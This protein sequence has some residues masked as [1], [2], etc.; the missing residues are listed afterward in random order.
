M[1]LYI[2]LFSSY[3]SN[4]IYRG[5]RSIIPSHHELEGALLT[6]DDPWYTSIIRVCLLLWNKNDGNDGSV[7]ILIKI[8]LVARQI[9]FLYQISLSLTWC[10]HCF[11]MFPTVRSLRAR[12]HQDNRLR[13]GYN[14]EGKR[15][16]DGQVETRVYTSGKPLSSVSTVP[17]FSIYLYFFG[18]CPFE[19]KG[20]SGLWLSVGVLV[21]AAHS[22]ATS[23]LLILFSFDTQRRETI[24]SRRWMIYKICR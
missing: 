15:L 14:G 24:V 7:A 12:L 19:K 3:P 4:V 10:V 2:S 5:I 20:R 21:T 11:P 9:L 16:S 8:S 1:E 22:W 17:S 13:S 18:L 6:R 23:P